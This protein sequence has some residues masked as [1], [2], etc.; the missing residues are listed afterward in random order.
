[1]ED[2]YYFN[3]CYVNCKNVKNLGDIPVHTDKYLS[4]V[5]VNI[6]N[7]KKQRTYE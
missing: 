5:H 1:M 2:D 6:K 7:L 4:V 3:S